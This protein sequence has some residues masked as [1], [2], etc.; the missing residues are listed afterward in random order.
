MNSPENRIQGIEQAMPAIQDRAVIEAE[1]AVV[2][3]IA[4]LLHSLLEGIAK[5]NRK[6]AEAPDVHPDFFIFESLPGA[7]AALAPRWLAA[8]GS[9]R[10][11]YG[12]AAE[13]QNT[14]GSHR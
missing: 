13:V 11:R 8:M 4:Q 7:G 9:Q 10:D 1:G 3:V 2:Q 14:A 6:I 12:N 5:L